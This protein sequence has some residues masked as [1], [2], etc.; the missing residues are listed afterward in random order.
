MLYIAKRFT[1]LIVFLLLLSACSASNNGSVRENDKKLNF[2]FNIP[3]QTLDP[4]LDVNYTSVRAGI[5]ETLVKITSDL[6]IEPWLAKD[7]KSTD[8]QTWVFSIRDDL[9]FQNG[10]KADAKA[11]KA[12][13]ERAIHD[14][15]AIKNALK[16]KE[17]KA[18]GQRLTIKTTEPFPEFP[19]ELVHPNTA[20]IDVSETN[21]S[22]KPIG[23]GPFQ[24]T[25]FE[26]GHRIELERYENYWNGKPKLK[27]ATFSFNE[28]AN[29]RMLALQ[30]KDADIIYRPSV[31]NIE[32]MEKDPAIVVDSVPSLRVH[33]L[34]YNMKKSNLSEV[35]L[36]QALDALLNRK[37]I[38]ENIMAGQ[39]QSAEGPFLKKFPFSSKV[40]QKPSGLDAAKDELKK[41]GYQFKDGKAV[42]N[43]KALS[44]TLLTY[45]SRPELPLIAQVFES[46]A[47]QL[48][49]SIKIQQVENIDEYLTE[50]KDW[51][52]A[53][54]SAMTA[55]RGDAG[56]FLNTA[57][58]PD[59]ALNYS[60][61]HQ[62]SLIKWIEEFNHTIDK[63]KRNHLAKKAADFIQKETLNSFIVTP[64]NIT[65]YR[66]YVLNW[67]TSK[68]EYYMLTKDLDV[69]TE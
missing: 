42:K 61:V 3:S 19:S 22:Q 38:A 12:S 68:S 23:T 33:Q 53:T 10:K 41:A 26:P 39:A 28:D 67:E 1:I 46:N 13:L 24:V 27:Q 7:W 8:G 31:E 36:R 57:Y 63:D 43:G 29:A 2:L 18:Q 34:L 30:S 16:V 32:H 66:D 50:N 15:K 62:Q 11:V 9:T 56:Y 45:Q 25:S 14:S 49:I 65:A 58:M 51:D 59:G 5:S 48:G 40:I 17:M 20:I 54:Y 21:F 60:G 35:H 4:H 47:K 52:L 69:K 6:T 64:Q 37:E 55:P 44:L